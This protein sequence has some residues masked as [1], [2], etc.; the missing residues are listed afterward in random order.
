MYG[1]IWRLLPGNWFVKLIF[2]LI[3]IAAV[4][5]LLMQYVFPVVAP[6]MPFNNATVTDGNGG[7]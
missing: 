4:V 7:Q 2:A 3:L 6:Y 5:L 1:L